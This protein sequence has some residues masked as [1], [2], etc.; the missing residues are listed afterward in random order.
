M[1]S[2]LVVLVFMMVLIN[3]TN[4]IKT[5]KDSDNTIQSIKNSEGAFGPKEITPPDLPSNNPFRGSFDREERFRTRYFI[6]TFDNSND[7]VVNSNTE[8]IALS[9][10]QAIEL[11]KKINVGKSII[12]AWELGLNEPK[13]SNLIAIADFFDVSIDYLAGR[14][15]Y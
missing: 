1:L 11:A 15:D 4:Y 7:T 5:C 2:L 10:D 14:V 12:S 13:L 8:N 3:T 6:I 9:N